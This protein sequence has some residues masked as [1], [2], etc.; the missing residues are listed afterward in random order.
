MLNLPVQGNVKSAQRTIEGV[1]VRIGELAETAGTTAK[2][3]RFYEEQGL[4]PPARRTPSGYRDYGT[5]T[6]ARIDFIHRGQA[7]G[8]TLA[9]IRQVLRIRDVGHA[10]CEHVRDLL[11]RRLTDLDTQIQQLRAL[12]EAISE[13]RDDAESVDPETCPPDQVCRYL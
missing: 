12:R 13:L 5:A 3:L 8:L 4:L 10:P 9:Q 2:T 6:L 1:C 11:D 7:A